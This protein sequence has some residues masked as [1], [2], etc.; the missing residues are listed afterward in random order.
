[1]QRNSVP[2]WSVCCCDLRGVWPLTLD[3]RGRMT[4]RKKRS[5]KGSEGSE[6]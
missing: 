4:F 6:K 2:R 1:M 5:P 3:N